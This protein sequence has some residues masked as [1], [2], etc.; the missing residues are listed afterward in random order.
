M[1]NVLLDPLPEDW[2]GYP[3]DYDFQTGIQIS[4]CLSDPEISDKERLW[5]AT[6]LL[7]PQ[8]HPAPE[9]VVEAINWYMTAFDHDNHKGDGQK[10]AGGNAPIIMDWDVDQWRIYAA[11]RSQYG[12]DL[13]REK[14]HWFTF[15]GL[16]SNLE[17]CAFTRVMEIRQK[18]VTAKM[19]TEEKNAIRDAKKIFEIKPPKDTTISPAEQEK[20]DAFLQYANIKR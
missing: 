7:F 20:I 14:L 8:E 5:I 1:F 4:Q 6:K 10:Q 2:N 19:S 17:E 16:L 3:I 9:E 13:N 15:M 12:L 11:F 18:K